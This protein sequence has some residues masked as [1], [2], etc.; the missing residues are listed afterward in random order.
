V[1][2]VVLCFLLWCIGLG[3]IVFG[4]VLWC[5]VGVSLTLTLT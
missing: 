4:V 5:G 2:C 1:W 3:W